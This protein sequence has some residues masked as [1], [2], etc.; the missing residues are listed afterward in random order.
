[1]RAKSN[2]L[3]ITVDDLNYDS[4]GCFGCT[5]D[6]ITP[7]I[8]KLA[9]EGIRFTNSH[10]TI[11]VC[12]PSRSTLL[13]GR[14]PHHNGARGFEEIDT[15]VTTLTQVLSQHG[16]LNGIIGKEDHIAPK[17]KFFWDEY[18]STYNEDNGFGRVPE[19]YYQHVRQFLKRAKNEQRPF[20]LMANSHDPHRPFAGSDD[21]IFYF[22][23]HTTPDRTYSPEEIT[24][25][26]C[27]PDLEGVR[28]ELAQYFSSAHRAD[29]T[30]GRILDALDDEGFRDNTLVL[31]LSDNGMALPYAKTNCYLNSTK[32]PYIL[33]WPGR[34][35]AGTV[36]DAL[37]SGIDFTPTVL[38]VLG[39]PPIVGVDGKSM[40]ETILCG[41]QHHDDIFTLFFKTNNNHVTHQALSYPMRCVQDKRF[42]YIFNSWSDGNAVFLN[43]STEG[44]TFRAM[45]QAAETD[46]DISRRVNFFKYRVTEE[47]YDYSLDPQALCN[48]AEYPEYQQL[49]IRMRQRMHEYMEASQDPLIDDFC[50]KVYKD[51]T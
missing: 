40:K 24:V 36:S 29:Q 41:S 19:L 42:A 4:V 34:V 51:L 49:L 45:E 46:E 35:A 28:K 8:D 15:S 21:E 25:P 37:V 12:Q 5:V 32:S 31:F 33:R 16:F 47:L 27:L 17:E 2:I 50:R 1:M 18:I 10:V 38:D 30:V 22:G 44:L 3:L 11:A 13:T 7:N 26:G 23:R 39:I 9:S 20:F 6:N 48:L 43:E 14:Y